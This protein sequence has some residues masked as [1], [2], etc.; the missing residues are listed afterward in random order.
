[1]IQVSRVLPA[2]EERLAT[3][4]VDALLMDAAR[5]LND[6]EI[7]LVVVCDKTDKL[8]G[9]ITKTDVVRRMSIC[10]GHSCRMQATEAMSGDVTFCR[11][12]DWLHDVWST[13]RRCELKN[14]PIVNDALVPMGVLNVR[15]ALQ[16]LLQDVQ[17]EEELLRDYVM[18]VGYR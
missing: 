1:M 12:D 5:L 18:G 15:D 13:I 2:A 11:P 4:R 6:P 8:A 14:M 9:V 16:A 17:N 3:I 7:N 10:T